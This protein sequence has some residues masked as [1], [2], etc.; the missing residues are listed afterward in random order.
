MNVVPERVELGIDLRDIDGEE[1][2]RATAKIVDLMDGISVRRKVEIDWEI[3]SDEEPVPMSR[4]II[5]QLEKTA[6]E[7]GI[8][9]LRL[10]SGAGHDAMNMARITDAGM[11]FVPSINGVSHNIAEKSRMED[12][13]Q[14]TELLL[15]AVVALANE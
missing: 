14:G 1:K 9:Y 5:A 2:K 13:R 15:R 8:P 7:T 12:I 4:K 10:P 11:I 3:L 6:K